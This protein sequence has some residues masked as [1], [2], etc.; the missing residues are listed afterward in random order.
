MVES[1]CNVG[2]LGLIPGLGRRK[3]QTTLVFLPGKFHGQ[4]NLAGYSPWGHKELD[5]TEHPHSHDVKA[6]VP[7]TMFP[8]L[9]DFHVF[10]QD[11]FS[12]SC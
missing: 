6:K 3:W 5:I 4:R 2:D 8:L 10:A 11:G 1:A 12:S 7:S 9:C